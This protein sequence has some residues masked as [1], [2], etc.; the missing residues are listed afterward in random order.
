MSELQATRADTGLRPIVSAQMTG[1]IAAASV[2]VDGGAGNDANDGSPAKPFKSVQRGVTAAAA[3]NRLGRPVTVYIKPATYREAVAFPAQKYTA[4]PIALV[5]TVPG[6]AVIDGS[7]LYTGW[8]RSS[9][10]IYTHTWKPLPACE[11]PY[12]PEHCPPGIG[13]RREMVFVNGQLLR[14][15]AS[16]A[17]MRAGTYT[18][19]DGARR[20]DV[21]T[22]TG[23]SP[24][25]VTTT[26]SIRGGLFSATTGV[27]NLTLNGLVVRGS[28]DCAAVGAA[29]D[30][31]NVADVVLQD[32]SAVW[33]NDE[34]IFIGGA[35]GR[36]QL[37]RVH[38][39]NNGFIGMGIHN[40]KSLRATDSTTNGNNWRGKWV[41]FGGWF[42]S[43]VKFG[44][45]HDATITRWTSNDP[46]WLD[47]DA[48]RVTVNNL[49]LHNGGGLI[50]ETI[51]GPVT[52]NNLVIC[53]T[54]PDPVQG[55]SAITVQASQNVSIHSAT[56]FLHNPTAGSLIGISIGVNDP[57]SVDDWETKANISVT[58]KSW[59][60]M[61]SA[62][63][64]NGAGINADYTVETDGAKRDFWSTLVADYNVYW[65]PVTPR[66]W[67]NGDTPESA[68]GFSTYKTWLKHGQEAHSVW[69]NPFQNNPTGTC[70]F[71]G[72]RGVWPR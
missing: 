30:I 34:G 54:A 66:V 52:F 10:A 15:V 35:K 50:L 2:Y 61:H 25:S 42:T 28:S 13:I 3:Q 67:Q 12:D 69:A 64:I 6:G 14:Q 16:R 8:T 59:T 11:C 47:T 62:I 43:G 21:W 48:T 39:D 4:A 17:A 33:N 70:T 45:L 71:V 26:V 55:G 49:L 58:T 72:A 18:V 27:Q 38:A 23:A 36:F 9:G 68:A 65:D 51:Q 41:K 22:P 1:G 20:L 46:F 29:I 5:G 57:A 37:T 32:V 56:I 53:P 44:G 60:I 7:D 31:E 40:T 24:D 63:V 19:D